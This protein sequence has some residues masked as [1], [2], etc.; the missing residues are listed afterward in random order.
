MTLAADAAP[1]LEV[2]RR[3][4]DEAS[5]M[6]EQD[7]LSVAL[8]H[9]G[10]LDPQ[11]VD[12]IENGE[13]AGD[14]PGAVASVHRTTSGEFQRKDGSAHTKIWAI[15]YPIAGLIIGLM[16]HHLYKTLILG[17]FEKIQ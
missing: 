8:G 3:F 1:N 17:Y 6:R 16:L 11:L 15:L 5:R 13:L 12:V 2:A 14:V 7:R 9:T 4:R 10:L